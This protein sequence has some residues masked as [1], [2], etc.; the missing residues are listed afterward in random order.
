VKQGQ[1]RPDNLA[2]LDPWTEK[3]TDDAVPG[4]PGIPDGAR[5]AADGEPR[6]ARTRRT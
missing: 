2:A 1:P 3:F 6:R 5:G 4:E